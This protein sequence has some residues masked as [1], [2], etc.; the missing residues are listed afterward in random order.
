M[1]RYICQ[2]TQVPYFTT[3]LAWWDIRQYVEDYVSGNVTLRR[4][5]DGFVYLSYYHLLAKRG[6][7]VGRPA[8]WLYD[9]FQHHRRRTLPHE[10]KGLSRRSTH[11]ESPIS[12][13]SP[14]N[15]FE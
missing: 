2:A 4:M 11:S 14:A 3:P 1:T 7:K 10:G 13:Y 8:R 15:W 12:I 5:F 6:N 9:R